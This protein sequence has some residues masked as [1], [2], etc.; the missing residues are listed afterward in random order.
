MKK[1]LDITNGILEIALCR[2]P[3]DTKNVTFCR[4]I[5]LTRNR[6][7]SSIIKC[8]ILTRFTRATCALPRD[9]VAAQ[10][11]SVTKYRVFKNTCKHT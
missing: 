5:I 2:P 8:F 11:S 7:I 4:P 1:F 6:T 3:Q 9:D 10:F